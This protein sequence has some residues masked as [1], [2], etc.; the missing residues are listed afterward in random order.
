MTHLHSQGMM[1]LSQHH[2]LPHSTTPEVPPFPTTTTT[3][4]VDNVSLASYLYPS[5]T[6]TAQQRS[7]LQRDPAVNKTPIQLNLPSPKAATAAPPHRRQ[8]S[9]PSLSALFNT[10][11]PLPT[12]TTAGEQAEP[13][14]IAL[15][16]TTCSPGPCQQQQSSPSSSSSALIICN[17]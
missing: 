3:T 12:E 7:T 11:N 15:A 2:H 10:D 9:D 13:G 6:T 16:N 17:S 8:E 5:L 1:T 4:A 14:S